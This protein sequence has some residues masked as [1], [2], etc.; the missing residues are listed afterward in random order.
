MH[1]IYW[2]RDHGVSY[3]IEY[4]VKQYISRKTPQYG[5]FPPYVRGNWTPHPFQPKYR[6]PS[7]KASFIYLFASYTFTTLKKFSVSFISKKLKHYK[8]YKTVFFNLQHWLLS[9][10]IVK[11]LGLQQN[12][13]HSTDTEAKPNIP[14][15]PP[16]L[17]ER[18]DLP[19]TPFLAKEGFWDSEVIAL[20]I[21]LHTYMCQLPV[22][23]FTRECLCLRTCL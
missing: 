19:L 3:L 7:N 9:F 8:G 10:W 11:H 2:V 14:W 18:Q 13:L 20:Y 4:N 16:T 1:V 21:I 23:G 22:W 6:S 12:S 5:L 15:H 17:C